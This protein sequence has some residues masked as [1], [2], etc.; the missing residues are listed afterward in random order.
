[1][2]NHKG[3]IIIETERLLLRKFEI[4]DAED[5]FYNWANDE[6]VANY[7][8]WDAHENIEET[9]KQIQKLIN[10][11]SSISTYL[12]FRVFNYCINIHYVV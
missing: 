12:K 5:M 8:R 1:M 3:T 4:F 2:L 6:E 9:Y 7:M 10:S 11:Y